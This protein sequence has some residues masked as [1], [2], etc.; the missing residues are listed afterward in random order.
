MCYVPAV[1][2]L[3]ISKRVSGPDLRW[4]RAAIASS[5]SSDGKVIYTLPFSKLVV[6]EEICEG[7]LGNSNF[8]SCGRT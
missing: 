7:L 6:A 8:R 3:L 4:L 2:I 1:A 5:V